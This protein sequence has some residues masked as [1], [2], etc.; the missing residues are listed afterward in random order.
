MK[1][2]EF[3]VMGW[4]QFKDFQVRWHLGLGRFRCSGSYTKGWLRMVHQMKLNLN[5]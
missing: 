3:T 2:L 5:T 1:S 4:G